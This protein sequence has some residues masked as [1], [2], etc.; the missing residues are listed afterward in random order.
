[1][2]S[3]DFKTRNIFLVFLFISGFQ[4]WISSYTLMS[5]QLL[6]DLYGD[7]IAYKRI[8]EIIEQQK[9]WEWL[10]YVLLPIIY[11][12]KFLLISSVLL[13]GLFL[14]DIKVQFGKVFRLVVEAEYIFFIPLII[15]WVWFAFIMRDYSMMD[16]TSFSP[17]SLSSL[18]DISESSPWL[19]PLFMSIN[20]FE[21]AYWV[22][23]A[24]GL[25]RL[26]ESNF[27][28][29]MGLVAAS[30]GSGWVV[31]QVLIIFLTINFSS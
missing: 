25:N 16:L 5:D 28:K 23:L 20:L 11:L 12:I 9:K 13:M 15:K 14:A 17:L 24:Y 26:L 4:A 19:T 18:I 2:F 21:V 22:L 10:G 27:R 3:T 30:Y 29:S 31:W 8:V 6:F 1:M 7:Q